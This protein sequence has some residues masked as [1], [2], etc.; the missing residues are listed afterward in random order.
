DYQLI[1]EPG[2][3]LLVID[4]V[5]DSDQKITQPPQKQM[6]ILIVDDNPVIL[7]LYTRLMRRAG[8]IPIKATN[9]REALE[10]IKQEKPDVVVLDFM[11]PILS[12]I[13][14]CQEVR[15]T[16]GNEEIILILFTSDAQPETRKRALE[17]GANAVVVKGSEASELIETIGY[18]LYQSQQKKFTFRHSQLSNTQPKSI[19]QKS[20][21]TTNTV[22]LPRLDKESPH[23]AESH[24]TMNSTTPETEKYS[25]FNP[26]SFME[27]CDGDRDFAE[28]LIALFQDNSRM[29][30]EEIK[31]AILE[32]DSQKLQSTAHTL[33][34]AVANFGASAAQSSAREMELLAKSQNWKAIEHQLDILSKELQKLNAE[35]KVFTEQR[36]SEL[37]G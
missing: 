11:L 32:R 17:A 30:L 7:R 29:L 36:I 12:G 20:A 34:G 10:L 33:K 27:L 25:S 3:K 31:S 16:I 35:L 21:S 23:Q 15:S 13:E 4:E 2:D 22:S 5:N 6:K 14:V 19:K 26:T 28:E 24:H 9:G 18:L 8:F 1:L 37:E